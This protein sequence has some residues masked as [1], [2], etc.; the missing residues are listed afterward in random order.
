MPSSE[1]NTSQSV[2]DKQQSNYA[3]VNVEWS[4]LLQDMRYGLRTFLRN[5]VF[6]ATA[7][8]TLALGIGANTAIFSVIDAVLLKPLPFPNPDRLTALYERLEHG[9]NIPV[10]PADFLDF[11]SQSKTFEHIA[12][13]RE[14]NFNI[15][16]RD[17]PERVAGIVATP[18]FFAVLG[19]QPELGRTLLP[20]QDKPGSPPVAVVS[21]SLWQRRWGGSHDVIGQSI[22]LDG[23]QRTIVGVM[24]KGFQ[25]PAG[26]D[27]WESARYA[28]PEHPLKPQV[29]QSTVRDSH[30]FE[31]IG[32]LRAGVDLK[33]AN[34]EA[35]T[36]MHRLKQQYGLDEETGA[37]IVDLHDDLVGKTRTTLLI[38][39]GA[40]TLLLFIACA[41]VANLLLARGTTHQVEIALRGALGARRTRLMHQLLTESLMLG[42]LG[43]GLGILLALSAL[44]LFRSLIPSDM[45]MGTGLQL[46]IPVL[47]FTAAVSIGAGIIFGLLPAMQLTK[48]DLNSVMK[49]G[50]RSASGDVQG[51]RTRGLLVVSEIALASVMLIGAGLLMRSFNRLLEVPEGFNPDKVLTMQ[52]SLPQSR[53]AN[54]DDRANFVNQMLS[55]VS[56][57]PGVGSA[58]VVS[59]LP[60]NPGGVTRS[61]E[62]Q[63]RTA[64]PSSEISPDYLVISPDYFR[65]MGIPLIAGRAFSERDDAKAPPAVIVSKTMANHFWPGEDPLGKF[66][67]I[68]ACKDWCQ[69]I[70]L[71][72][73]VQQHHLD[74]P[75]L[76]TVY[77]AYAQD[78]WQSLAV[79]VRTTNDPVSVASEVEGALHSVDKDQPVYKVL[80]M[81]EVVAASL[82]SQ[83][84][85]MMLL[86]AFAILALALASTGI[87]GVMA[88]SVAQRSHDIG[89]RMALGAQRGDILRLVLLQ[90]LRLA[91]AGI[92]I[93]LVLSVGL[94]RFM[95][96]VLYGLQAAD[97]I[98][99]LLVAAG[100][101]LLA[102][103]AGY[104]PAR[105][106]VKINPVEA[107]RLG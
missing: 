55:K 43:G 89:V 16:G 78:P 88:Y 82:S 104:I 79:A 22:T 5:P 40:V 2:N 101:A 90:S 37:V 28:V 69:V 74:Q 63:G 80:P 1:R 18:D 3:G 41:N 57:L 27:V 53:Y 24:R 11:R 30:Y 8:I 59:R 6:T 94:L 34:A 4:N 68:G 32:R 72:G 56:T 58:A 96:N 15:T 33:Q 10:A 106:A 73:D 13:Y 21:Y 46:S 23:E 102:M 7:V 67:K 76:P 70:G 86:A 36:I 92:A 49:A 47:I 107:L 17:R 84:W 38:L 66:V 26:S 12:A 91:L 9:E 97:A 103:F 83:R 54:P 95:T 48:P 50:G 60:L 75:P 98:A 51:Y 93:G 85:R 19:V 77:A 61:I 81:R 45:V 100:L 31:T 44:K 65:T 42:A 25:F 87:Y 20:E 29:D 35:A 52:I 39:L 105:R 71:T 99:F 14:G 62:I 64:S